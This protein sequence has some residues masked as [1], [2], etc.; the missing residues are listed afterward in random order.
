MSEAL[1]IERVMQIGKES[2]RLL[3]SHLS[4]EELDAYINPIYRQKLRDEGIE[5]GIEQGKRVMYH[6]LVQVLTHR[7]GEMPAAVET[8]LQS[9]TLDQL[10][11]LVNPV[12]D[13]A[14][15]EEFAAL[16]PG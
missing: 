10:N 4:P 15:W 1:T 7:L 5:Q 12:L 14:T 6:T 16:L 3:L 2:K 11:A 8:R 13:V 9:C